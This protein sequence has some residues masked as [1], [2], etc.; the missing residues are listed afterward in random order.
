MGFALTSAEL[1]QDMSGQRSY[2]SQTFHWQVAA[3]GRIA[4]APTLRAATPAAPADH[5]LQNWL[6]PSQRH[7]YL[8]DG[9]KAP[10]SRRPRKDRRSRYTRW[11]LT[12]KN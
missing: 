6:R 8:Q 10:T 7:H 1:G 5:L 12:N 3:G 2:F 9:R 11:V 4:A